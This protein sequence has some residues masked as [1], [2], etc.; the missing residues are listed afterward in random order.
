MTN[1]GKAPKSPAASSTGKLTPSQPRFATK[2]KGSKS[3]PNVEKDDDLG[4]DGGDE[5]IFGAPS[6]SMGGAASEQW[7]TTVRDLSCSN[8]ALSPYCASL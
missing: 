7:A 6:S 1:I 2:M 3:S 5:D 8:D 4:F